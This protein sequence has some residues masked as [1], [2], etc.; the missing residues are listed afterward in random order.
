[1]LNF[2]C[3][4]R[5]LISVSE[6]LEMAILGNNILYLGSIFCPLL[7]IFV[8]S[9]LCNLLLPESYKKLL[10]F[11]GGVVYCFVLTIGHNGLY[12]KSVSLNTTEPYHYLN[13]VYGPTHCLYPAFLGILVITAIVIIM[14]ARNHRDEVASRFIIVSSLFSLFLPLIYGMEKLLNTN[15]QYTTLGYLGL[16][17]YLFY[18]ADRVSVYDIQ[19]NIIYAIERMKEYGYIGFDKKF[20]F[21]GANDTVKEIFPEITESWI[22]DERVPESDSVLYQ[23]ISELLNKYRVENKKLI[24]VNNRY[25]EISVSDLAF[26]QKCKVGYLIEFVDKTAENEYLNK[27]K[28]YNEVL[29]K[30]VAEKTNN[31]SYMKDMLVVGMASMVESRDNSTGGHIKRTSLSM[32]VFAENLSKH[33]GE[34]H[35]S[36]DYINMI[37]RA[38]P[39]HDLGKM[40]VDDVI[41]RKQ[42]KYTEEEYNQMKKHSLEGVRIIEG[43]LR[44]VES[45]SFVNLCEN[46]AHYHHERYD[47]NGYPEG[48]SNTEIPIE[49][50]I[51]ALVDVFDALVS[52]RCY[53]EAYSYDEA[54]KII[55]D[56]LGSHFDPRL[57]RV[58][59]ECRPQLESLYNGFDLTKVV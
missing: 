5:F 2:V 42:G 25:F 52:K 11:L 12:Y 4:G 36:K 15:V 50:R 9:R 14:Y 26:N 49:A 6:T 45:D 22:I 37:V 34:F 1:M 56:S 23:Y 46:M 13:K 59:M 3:F 54:F 31:I 39:M 27:M 19:N 10:V 47:G 58:F 38:A 40:A 8:L 28:N 18:V 7:A 32:K 24:F 43:I 17:I 20:R 51:M 41:L 30:E 44:N 33:I 21:V 29:R 53:K 57:G 55:E 35:L 48:I 16:S